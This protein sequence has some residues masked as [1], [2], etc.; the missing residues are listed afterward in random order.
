MDLDLEEHLA[1]ELETRL[2]PD[3]DFVP[4]APLAVALM[5]FNDALPEREVIQL[6]D[7]LRFLAKDDGPITVATACSGTDVIPLT[8]KVHVFARE[9]DQDTQQFLVNNFPDMEALIADTSQL[10]KDWAPTIHPKDCRVELGAVD[11]FIA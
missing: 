5:A 10:G 6:V 2:E 3:D 4:R 7:Q 1:K 9:K 11:I 8:M